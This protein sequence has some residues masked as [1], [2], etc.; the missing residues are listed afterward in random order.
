MIY[1]RIIFA[2]LFKENSFYLSRNFSLQKVGDLNWLK[3]NFSFNETCNSIDEL[4]CLNI[5][6]DKSFKSKVKF[7]KMVNELRKTIFIPL[8]LGGG[9]TNKEEAKL[10]FDNGADK[11][12]ICTHLENLNL[13]KSISE[14]YG[15]QSIS[16]MLDY[17]KNNEDKTLIFSNSGTKPIK[18]VREFFSN[19]KILNLVG[20]VILNSIENDGVGMGLD[21]KIMK[22]LKKINNPILLM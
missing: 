11:I 21:L 4:V 22:N 12:S 3:N 9:I 7:I 1:K 6:K 19:K 8:T 14:E 15:S 17:K 20:E 16:L 2:L 13:I 18:S 10:Y 5:D